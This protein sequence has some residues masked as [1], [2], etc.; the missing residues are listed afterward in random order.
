[1][2]NGER[3]IVFLCNEQPKCEIKETTIPFAIV[4]KEIKYFGINCIKEVQG[5]YTEN[6]KTLLNEI[7][8]T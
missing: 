4:S 2:L 1:M 5:V 3:S 6:Y 8:K 7:L